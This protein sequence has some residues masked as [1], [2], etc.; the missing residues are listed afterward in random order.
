MRLVVLLLSVAILCGGCAGTPVKLKIRNT[1]PEPRQVG[2]TVYRTP[3][4]D[5]TDFADRIYT[6]LA[7]P[8]DTLTVD[9]DAPDHGAFL[10]TAWDVDVSRPL[11]ATWKIPVDSSHRIVTVDR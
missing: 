10:V 5:S 2:V 11:F 8:G 4:Y 3:D 7:K 9:F 6:G 1:S